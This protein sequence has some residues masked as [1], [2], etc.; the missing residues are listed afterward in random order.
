M[1]VRV[2]SA[3]DLEFGTMA[4]EVTVS[5]YRIMKGSTV[6]TIDELASTQTI[7]V[8]DPLRMPSGL[9]DI[10]YKAG[11]LDNA[12][13]LAMVTDYWDGETF[14]VD[15]LTDASTV[16][17]DSGYTQQSRSNFAISQEND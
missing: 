3:D 12:G 15:I 7:A 10:V 5:H 8:G 2:Q 16:V 1:A 17:S 14:A 11:E 6:V 4:A 13:L 9:L